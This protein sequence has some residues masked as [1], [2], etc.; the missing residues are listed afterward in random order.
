MGDL[1]PGTEL[2]G[3]RIESVLGRGGMSVVYQALDVRLG[4][5][6]ALK[7]MA[8]EMAADEEFRK[9]FNRESR[10]AAAIDHPNIIP[11]YEAD[12]ADG[13][14]F[15]AMRFVEGTDLRGLIAEQGRLDPKRALAILGQAASALDAAHAAGLIHRDVKPANILVARSPEG[16][17][18]VYLTDFG[19]TKAT[20]GTEG[21]TRTGQ[22]VGTVQYAA[23]EQIEG[24]PV[25]ARTDVYALGCVLYQCLAGGPPYDRDSEVAVIFAHIQE[26]PPT[27]TSVRPE[28]PAAA[29]A[30][31]AKA[32]A[33]TK[34][35]RYPNCLEMVN[36]LKAVIDT[37]PAVDDG[38]FIGD[39]TL[40]GDAPAPV[41]IGKS[42]ARQK[43]LWVDS[44]KESPA[45]EV[46]VT[47]TARTP[48]KPTRR[49]GPVWVAVIL[50]VALAGAAAWRFWP[51]T[52][53]RTGDGV[54]CT[55]FADPTGAGGAARTVE[56][57]IAS[58]KPGETGC[59]RG[60]FEET[61]EI[62]DVRGITLASD[63][64]RSATLNGE[65]IVDRSANDVTVR[66][67][68]LTSGVAPTVSVGGDDFKLIENDISNQAGSCLVLGNALVQSVKNTEVTSNRIH[69]C[70]GSGIEVVR[71]NAA[72]IRGNVISANSG[73]GVDLYP[74]ATGVTVADNTIDG[75]RVGISIGGSTL[76]QPGPSSGNRVV[77]NIISN[78]E[79]SLAVRWE[80]VSPGQQNALDRNC[81]FPAPETLA[82][83]TISGGNE[84]V[85]PQFTDR[86]GGNYALAAGVCANKGAKGKF[87]LS[88]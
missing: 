22:F 4:R 76:S 15:I 49:R 24:M 59:L 12:E 8:P 5:K 46:A 42:S 20:E 39:T 67:L 83:I 53:P 54:T 40:A 19:V 1:Q 60:T 45:G 30:I 57:L 63:P 47:Q 82:G 13:V 86:A 52:T 55:R 26:P 73:A 87:P 10:M 43:T 88:A 23:P 68:K 38:T 34:V 33:K 9:R 21:L 37:M 69:N 85:D 51:A 71:A 3:Y 36:A 81:I 16:N 78:S 6:V 80:G 84:I 27:L 11:I 64:P 18:H 77:G 56:E 70:R 14:L 62:R 7:L 41:H 58:L 32:L 50:G 44:L 79:S 29:D 35:E 48:S 72:E 28:L 61:V 74:S 31:I 25:D 65:L 17:D 75:N 2:A 66:G